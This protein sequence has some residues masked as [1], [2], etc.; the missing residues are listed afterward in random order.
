[1][2]PDPDGKCDGCGLTSNLMSVAK[3]VAALEPPLA[4]T[5]T[6]STAE[7]ADAALDGF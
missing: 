2:Q 1:M 3:V 7:G 4:D 6:N 5:A